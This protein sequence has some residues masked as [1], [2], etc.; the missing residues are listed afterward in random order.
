MLALLTGQV[1]LPGTNTGAREGDSYGIDTG[2]PTG[3]NPVK[4]SFPIFFGPRL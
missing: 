4:V 2:L 3:K 1:G